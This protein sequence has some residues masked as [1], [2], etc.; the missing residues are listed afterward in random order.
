MS[1]VLAALRAVDY[2]SASSCRYR[3]CCSVV[4]VVAAV[5]VAYKQSSL[6]WMTSP[7]PSDVSVGRATTSSSAVCHVCYLSQTQHVCQCVYVKLFVVCRRHDDEVY[8]STMLAVDVRA[9]GSDRSG[10]KRRRLMTTCFGGKTTI[11]QSLMSM[12]RQQAS[13]DYRSTVLRA[14]VVPVQTSADHDSS[15]RSLTLSTSRLIYKQSTSVQTRSEQARRMTSVMTMSRCHG[16]CHSAMTSGERHHQTCAQHTSRH[17]SGYEGSS[18]SA[19]V[20]RGS[21]TALIACVC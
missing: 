17:D 21:L 18:P 9:E 13:L 4:V 11:K 5:V 1:V 12:D 16:D 14:D 3:W 10:S 19:H 15:M 20:S 6:M 7:P 8:L 2:F